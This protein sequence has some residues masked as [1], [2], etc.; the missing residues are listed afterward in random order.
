MERVNGIGG[1]FFKAH[2]PK[3]LAEWYEKHLGVSQIPTSYQEEPWHQ[4]AGSTAFAPFAQDSSYFGRPEQTWM[5]NFRVNDLQAMVA[6]LQA[7][8]IEVEVDPETYPN[9][10]FAR[11]ADPEGNPIQLW[12]PETPATN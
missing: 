4:Q 1:F 11:L 9:G 10:T 2:D 3:A 5:L 6:Q 12:Q 8:G 7:A